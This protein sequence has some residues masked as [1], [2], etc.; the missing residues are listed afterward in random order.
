[1]YTQLIE[2]DALACFAGRLAQYRYHTMDQA[3]AAT[4]KFA[5]SLL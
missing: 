4:L 5:Q 2:Q 1:M 3:V